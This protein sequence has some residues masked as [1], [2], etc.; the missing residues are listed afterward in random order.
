M[1]N[2]LAMEKLSKKLQTEKNLLESLLPSH[3][4]QGLREGKSVQPMM[5]NA[6]TMFFSDTIGF[7]NICKQI[8]PTEVIDM[9]TSLYIIMHLL[10]KK[11]NLFKVEMIG[12]AYVCCSGP[13]PS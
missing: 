3:T 8:S 11:F 2:V 7:T 13:P 5:H 6:V 9:L 10:A 4:A 12:D 1:N